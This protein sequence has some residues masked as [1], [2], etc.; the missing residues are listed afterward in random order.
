VNKRLE[1]KHCKSIQKA[2]TSLREARWAIGVMGLPMSKVRDIDHAITV[3][4]QLIEKI[5]QQ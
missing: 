3:L 5:E 1:A 2:S 4:D